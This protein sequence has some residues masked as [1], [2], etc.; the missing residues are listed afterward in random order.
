MKDKLKTTKKRDDLLMSEETTMFV[1]DCSSSMSYSMS[2]LATFAGSKTD[3]LK[4]AVVAALEERVKNP[5]LDKLGVVLFG[6][7]DSER[8]TKLLFRPEH[9]TQAHVEA[10]K[11][12]IYDQG[13]TPMYQGLVKAREALSDAEGLV[14]IILVTDGEPNAGFTKE[15]IRTLVRELAQ[16]DGYVIDTVGVGTSH[17]FDYDEKFL[18]ELAEIGEGEFYP[19]EDADALLRRFLEME[20]ERRAL[21]GSGIKLLAAS[22]K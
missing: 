4:R 6:G 5:S 16:D 8:S 12:K 7:N 11:T 22:Y 21:M 17:S 2:S 19:V 9:T 13:C 20:R 14:R 3:A 10:V 15:Q 1:L 18:K